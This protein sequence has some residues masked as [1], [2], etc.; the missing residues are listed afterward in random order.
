MMQDLSEQL[1]K[2]K[3][4]LDDSGPASKRKMLNDSSSMDFDEYTRKTQKKV[5]IYLD[6]C[7]IF[8]CMTENCYQHWRSTYKYPSKQYMFTNYL[9]KIETKLNGMQQ[10]TLKS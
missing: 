8:A 10:R 9:R 5:V 7:T 2:E 6:L 4:K 1:Q 3:E